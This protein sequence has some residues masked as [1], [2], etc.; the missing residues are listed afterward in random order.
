MPKYRY[1]H[2]FSQVIVII[3]SEASPY[4]G[5]AF[6]LTDLDRIRKYNSKFSTACKVILI[7]PDIGRK[8]FSVRFQLYLTPSFF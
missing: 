8:A 7:T 2:P 3:I 6:R 5:P 4:L 1:H